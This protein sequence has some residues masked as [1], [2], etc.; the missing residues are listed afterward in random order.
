MSIP[1]IAIHANDVEF[2]VCLPPVMMWEG[3]PGNDDDPHD[4][5]GRTHAG[6]IQTEYNAW[7]R[8]NNLPLKDVWLASWDEVCEIYYQIYWLPWCP[9]L[10]RGVNLM[11]FDQSINQ[12]LIQAVRNLQRALNNQHDPGV[13]ARI[14]RNIGL[15][16]S[17][18][19]IDGH[20][21]PLTLGALNALTVSG[22][23]AFLDTYYTQDL[24]FY[25]QLKTWIYY[26]KGWTARAL[27]IYQQATA[28]LVASPPPA[29]QKGLRI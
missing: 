6:I 10:W 19:D 28:L 9:Q 12:G 25:H 1:A 4:P 8:A 16:S 5:G 20:L 17:L 13:T 15:R 14:L 11:L 29:S 27:S 24:D 2:V 18:V 26:G 7:R 22:R 23:K 21:G 3:Y